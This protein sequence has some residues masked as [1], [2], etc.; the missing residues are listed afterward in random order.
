MPNHYERR[1]FDDSWKFTEGIEDLGFQFSVDRKFSGTTPSGKPTAIKGRRGNPTQKQM[2]FTN[3]AGMPVQS[4]DQVW[5]IWSSTFID[6]VMPVQGDIILVNDVEDAYQTLVS[7]TTVIE[8]W[9]VQ[10]AKWAVYGA[11]YI[12]YCSESPLTRDVIH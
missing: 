8:R 6:D 11:Q 1:Y 7:P 10:W 12:C 5:T 3:A 4:S 9:I 2:V